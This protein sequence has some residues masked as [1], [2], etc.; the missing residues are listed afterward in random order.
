MSTRS[1]VFTSRW[2][3]LLAMMGMA[4]GTGNIWRFPRIAAT[5]GGGSFLVAWVVFLLLWSIPLLILEFGLGKGTRSGP[6][7]AFIATLGPKF[8]WMG[9]WIAWTATAIMFYYS[10]VMGWT[11]RFFAAAALGEVP[12]DP[13]AGLWDSYAGS[14]GALLTHAIAMGLG[15][16]VVSRGVRG[17]ETAARILIPSL[18]VLVVILAIRAVTLPGASAGLAFL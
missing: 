15:V 5:Q 14:P 8:G 9:A 16:F 10:V 1:A 3:M 4:V 13:P 11:L 7:G 6:V 12:S 2:G 17:I 18:V